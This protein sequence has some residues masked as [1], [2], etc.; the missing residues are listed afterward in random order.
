[1]TEVATQIE[2]L[3]YQLKGQ[4]EAIERNER[5]TR[6]MRNPDF[7]KLILEEFC[8]QECARYAQLSADPSLPDRERADALA[9]AQSAGHLRRWLNVVNQMGNYAQGQVAELEQAIVDVR[10]EEDAQGSNE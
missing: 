5:A 10:A 1:M 9:L 3:E 7:K 8:V 4:R 2:A 6:L